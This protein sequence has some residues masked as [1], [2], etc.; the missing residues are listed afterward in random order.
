MVTAA[1]AILPVEIALFEITGFVAEEPTPAKSPASCSIPFEVVV[2][3]GVKEEVH[4]GARVEPLLISNLL[5]VR[6]KTTNP[7][8][9]N[10]IASR[11]AVVKRG[12]KKPLVVLFTSN[13][14]DA[15]GFVVVP[16]PILPEFLL[17]MSLPEGLHLLLSTSLIVPLLSITLT[18]CANEK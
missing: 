8:A 2:A 16:I 1:S 14:A 9:G 7:V 13:L 4:T 5:V 12:G 11:C 17:Y 15:S 3:S 18:V 6:L 10:T